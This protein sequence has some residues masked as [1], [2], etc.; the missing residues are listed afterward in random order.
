[1]A[2]PDLKLF[3]TTHNTNQHSSTSQ[4]FQQTIQTNPDHAPN[5]PNDCANSPKQLP[6]HLHHVPQSHQDIP[7]SP[8][9][10]KKGFNIAFLLFR[11]LGEGIVY[12]RPQNWILHKLDPWALLS[13][14][15]NLHPGQQYIRRLVVL[16]VLSICV[17]SFKAIDRNLWGL[18]PECLN[19]LFPDPG[20]GFC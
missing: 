11:S 18:C 16:S 1:M 6:Q 8:W 5:S 4:T 20:E 7:K 15:G 9:K 13:S 10:N 12:A 17:K 14:S 2:A 19:P 3:A